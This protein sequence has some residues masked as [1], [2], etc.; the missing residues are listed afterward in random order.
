MVRIKCYTFI[1]VLFVTISYFKYT[2]FLDHQRHLKH[3]AFIQLANLNEQKYGNDNYPFT[4]QLTNLFGSL[5]AKL[6]KNHYQ[7]FYEI[8][9]DSNFHAFYRNTLTLKGALTKAFEKKLTTLNDTTRESLENVNWFIDAA[10]SLKIVRTGKSYRLDTDYSLLKIKALKSTGTRDDTFIG[11]YEESYEKY[12]FPTWL[13]K[14]E[15][16]K[17]F[18]KLGTGIH[19]AL[20]SK[21][22]S[23]IDKG[24]Y[25]EKEILKIKRSIVTDLLFSK[26]FITSRESVIKE[27]SRISSTYQFNGKEKEMLQTKLDKLHNTDEAFTFQNTSKPLLSA[28][29]D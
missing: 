2:D 8:E 16:K 12:Y 27:L 7:E 14:N 1:I 13:G 17:I 4:E 6:I 9:T 18:S 21:V 22:E 20:L 11:L 25:F 10:P 24:T 29:R 15:E 5:N 28:I 19:Y 26:T 3:Q 23:E